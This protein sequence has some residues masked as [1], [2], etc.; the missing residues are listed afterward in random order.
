MLASPII[1]A[2]T[3][4]LQAAGLFGGRI[5]SAGNL[6]A[7]MQSGQASQPILRAHVL[8]A[9]LTGRPGSAA[10]GAFV[11]TVERGVS[12]L[13]TL[14]VFDGTGRSAADVEALIASTV[15]ALCGWGPDDFPGVFHLRLGRL[16]SLTGGI[17]LYQL[18]F[19]ITD[20]LRLSV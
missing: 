20:Q 3:A 9:D 8:P 16:L 5:E 13:I 7:L 6:A 17:I 12:V 11:Q 10:A 15:A 19:T 18:D 14:P 4:R 1:P 2:V